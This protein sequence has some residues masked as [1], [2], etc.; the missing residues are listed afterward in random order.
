MQSYA[1][2]EHVIAFAFLGAMF[3]LGYPK[4]P[5]LAFGTVVGTAAVLEILQTMTPDRHGT[6]TGAL[7]KMAVGAAGIAIARAASGNSGR[8]AIGHPELA[9]TTPDRQ[10]AMR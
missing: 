1:H 8:P 10:R 4:R 9:P 6:L 3:G 5:L 7:E 2:F